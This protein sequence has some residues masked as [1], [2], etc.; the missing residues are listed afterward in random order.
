MSKTRTIVKAIQIFHL[1]ADQQ[2]HVE[3]F[4]DRRSPILGL[5]LCVCRCSVIPNIWLVLNNGFSLWLFVAVLCEIAT[6]HQVWRVLETP[7]RHTQEQEHAHILSPL[8]KLD[9]TVDV[10]PGCAQMHRSL[11]TV[12]LDLAVCPHGPDTRLKLNYR[13]VAPG[14]TR[15]LFARPLSE[16]CLFSHS[17][18]GGKNISWDLRK[19]MPV[20]KTFSTES[21]VP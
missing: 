13:L 16:K 17:G 11:C 3:L 6:L 8:P 19:K 20:L 10:T 21:L 9:E 14:T 12:A 7:P 18:S 15:G 5:I 2:W 4:P 1:H